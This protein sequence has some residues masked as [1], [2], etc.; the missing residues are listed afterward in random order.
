MRIPLCQPDER[1]MPDEPE[2]KR[3][4]EP[5]PAIVGQQ[6]EPDHQPEAGPALGVEARDAPREDALP[7]APLNRHVKAQN[8][9]SHD[10]GPFL[11]RAAA[12]GH[13]WLAGA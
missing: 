4:Y 2:A 13:A 6:D 7:D 8:R 9:L 10:P 11:S 1:A 12:G 3:Q 5:P